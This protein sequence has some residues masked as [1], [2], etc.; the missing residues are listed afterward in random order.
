MRISFQAAYAQYISLLLPGLV[1]NN[2]TSTIKIMAMGYLVQELISQGVL[3]TPSIIEAFTHVDRRDF[4]PQDQREYAYI[5]EPL[6]IGYGQT[7]S[8]PMVVAFMLELLKPKTGEKILDIGS[9]S[10][11]QIALL[12]YIVSHDKFGKETNK[13][14]WGRVVGIELLPELARM[15][16]NNLAKYNFIKKRIAAIH[17]LNAQG[18]YG[19]EA[20]YDKILSA[21]SGREVPS[22]W[23]EQLKIGKMEKKSETHHEEE[24]FPGFAFVPFIEEETDEKS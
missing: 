21:A 22:A 14:K 5:N 23:R 2:K 12:S 9:G 17:C 1:K 10:G 24:S 20:P 8:Q 7:I 13:D 15:G 3:K 16:I 18:G 19:S 6:S 11:W 4:V